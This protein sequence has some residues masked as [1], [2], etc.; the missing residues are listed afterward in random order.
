MIRIRR[1]R[2][3]ITET[4]GRNGGGSLARNAGTNTICPTT[5]HLLVS[6]HLSAMSSEKGIEILSLRISYHLLVSCV[7]PVRRR[8]PPIIE[9]WRWVKNG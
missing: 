7:R 5:F 2:D 3:I 8:R 9:M 6:I 4:S 1:G